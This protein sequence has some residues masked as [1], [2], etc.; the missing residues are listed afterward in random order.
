MRLHFFSLNAILAVLMVLCTVTA[1]A[2]ETKDAR[3]YFSKGDEF[4]FKLKYTDAITSYNKAISMDAGYTIAY[5]KRGV[6]YHRIKQYDKAIQDCSKAISLEP[7]SSIF[8]YHRGNA[9]NQSKNIDS[10]IAD[11]TTAIRLESVAQ[12]NNQR[13]K[14]YYQSRGDFYQKQQA[15]ELAI[16]DYTKLINLD[17]NNAD[18]YRTRSKA[19]YYNNQP[20]SALQ[21][22]TRVFSF[23]SVNANNNNYRGL[24]YNSLG[25]YE[26]SILDFLT[27]LLKFPDHG[28][29]YINIISP[30]V[31]LQRFR[32]AA[33]FYKLYT[34]KKLY[35]EINARFGDK[36]FESFLT[37]DK[38]KFYNYYLKAVEQVAD[39]KWN[40]ALA[41]LDT[42][43][44]EYGTESKDETKRRYIDVLSL[45]GYVLEKLERY[46]EARINYDQSL[47][48]DP[49]QPD[50]G[51]ALVSLQKKMTLSRSLNKKKAEIEIK[52]ANVQKQNRGFTIEA[53]SSVLKVSLIGEVK[54]DAGI[55]SL[56]INGFAAYVNGSTFFANLTL[57]SDVSSLAITAFNK[58]KDS[59]T[60]AFDLN[61]LTNNKFSA[62]AN[63]KAAAPEAGKYYAVLIAEKDYADPSIP[64]LRTPI[65]DAN[66]LRDILIKQYTFDST[67]VDT[68]YNRSRED[69]I[70]T[71]IAR[72]KKMTDKDNLLIFYAGHGDT[73]IDKKGKIDGYLVPSS[74][75]K[76]LTSYYITSEDIFKA[77]LRSNA[78]HILILLDACYSGIFTRKTSPEVPNDIKKQYE[79]ESRKVMS[80]GNIE[81]VPDN[82]EFIYHLTEYLKKN[83][84]EKYVSAKDLWEDVSKKVKS[85]L[86][87]YAALDEAG[88]FGGQ[89]IFEKRIK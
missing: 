81:E 68:L 50:L 64:D 10:A 54:D 51:E 71:I 85:T 33:L 8:Y 21:D 47:I 32:E 17:S 78:K 44:K 62:P 55:D 41:S 88:D 30:L 31:R 39:S 18:F 66:N 43:S 57:K 36:K 79:L 24:F 19:Y 77:L 61:E 89:F 45:N 22:I 26:L 52:T 20:D 80:S 23:D 35:K 40:E 67:N 49:R 4:L 75:K 46:E 25:E 63:S 76:A 56:K 28:N 87:Q 73:T 82:S 38:Y 84:Q 7:D 72:C 16:Q 37:Q 2:Q 11:Y 86:A 74:A 6:S 60:K 69:I 59:T 3:Y 65:R 70:E 9:Y 1:S 14:N 29:P 53:D 42:A 34:E 12:T 15:H 13:L 58:Q 5:Y 48:I 83:T 27:Y